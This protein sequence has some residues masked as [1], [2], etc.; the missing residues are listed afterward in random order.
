METKTITHNDQWEDIHRERKKKERARLI[1]DR[2]RK[3]TR[4][5]CTT[6]EYIVK[7]DTD[8]VSRNPS[9]ANYSANR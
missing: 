1:K 8:T 6:R 5:N 3:R 2:S 7:F 9:Q 4:E